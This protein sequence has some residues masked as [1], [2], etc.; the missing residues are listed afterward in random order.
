MIYVTHVAQIACENCGYQASNHFGS[1]L[2]CAI[3]GIEL[4]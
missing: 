2:Y 1:R 4:D 3:C